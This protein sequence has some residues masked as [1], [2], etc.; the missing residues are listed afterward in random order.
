MHGNSTPAPPERNDVALY[1]WNRSRQTTPCRI[2]SPTTVSAVQDVIANKYLY[3]GP[4]LAI[5]SMH[6]VTDAIIND[7]GTILD[8]SG[9]NQILGVEESAGQPVVRVQAGCQLKDLSD[10]LAKQSFELAFQAEIGNAT[11][12]AL[13]TGDS[14]DAI[15]DGPGYFSAYV[16]QVTLINGDGELVTLS[17]SAEPKELA[18]FCCSF[19]LHGV[20]VECL[21]AIQKIRLFCTLYSDSRFESASEL[22][23]AI[24]SKVNANRSLQ[25][26]VL[27]PELVVK[28]A[29]RYPVDQSI[30][31]S[32]EMR[33]MAE[34][35]RRQRQH[36]VARGGAAE[37]PHSPAEL[38]HYRWQLM[39]DFEP[40]HPSQPRLDFQLYE[41]DLA[42]LDIVIST[43]LE[44]VN[45]FHQRTGFKPNAWAFFL[46]HRS[47]ANAKP[48][49]LYSGGPGSSI[50][51]DPYHSDPSNN[52]WI[53]FLSLYNRVAID[54]LGA[55]VSP[56]QTQWLRP[57]DCHIPSSLIH[58]RF[59][60]PY[61]QEINSSRHRHE[62]S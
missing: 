55:R 4:V 36:F 5:G 29:E 21:V 11:I 17:Q 28:W 20:V 40:V 7:L 52:H 24:H 50:L 3:P 33:Q 38:V 39:N 27:I 25:C 46:V 16:R 62:C 54:E 8:L 53:E 35:Y 18:D 13:T 61:Y 9:L 10:W 15:H 22:S 43:T 1:N 2:I 45:V 31:Q 42:A 44:F 30:K 34:T 57:G 23:A 14:K 12:G 49:G 59:L 51:L 37:R 48:F 58:S 32:P 41:Y 6:S 26:N 47:E 60:T 19:G 56:I